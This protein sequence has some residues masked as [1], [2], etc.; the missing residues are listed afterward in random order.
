MPSIQR[1]RHSL[2]FLAKGPSALTSQPI[3]QLNITPLIDVLLVLLV[4]MML[5]IPIALHK[6]SIDLPT[7]GTTDKPATIH[8]LRLNSAGTAIWDGE[9]ITDT[10]LKTRLNDIALDPDLPQL[11]FATDGQTRYERFDNVIAIIK[12][13]GVQK[14]GFVGNQAFDRWDQDR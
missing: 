5:S 12:R 13:S 6:V 3:S 11:H 9:A 4:M 8:M 14:I 1:R 10:Q 2:K 7:G